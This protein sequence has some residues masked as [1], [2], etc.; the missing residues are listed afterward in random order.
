MSLF[1]FQLEKVS[2]DKSLFLNFL[3]ISYIQLHQ[4]CL[5]GYGRIILSLKALQ[6][7]LISFSKE[8]N[9]PP[10]TSTVLA[11]LKYLR[12]AIII[13]GL[14]TAICRTV[15][16]APV[17]LN[18]M[19]IVAI[20]HISNLRQPSFNTLKYCVILLA[21]TAAIFVHVHADPEADAWPDASFDDLF[22]GRASE[23]ETKN[24][25]QSDD[26]DSETAFDANRAIVAAEKNA[27]AEPHAD[28][29]LDVKPQFGLFV[30][31]TK[32]SVV[33]ETTAKSMTLS[34]RLP[35]AN[36]MQQ[37]HDLASTLSNKI[38]A[39]M[40][41]AVMTSS[42]LYKYRKEAITTNIA[43]CLVKLKN[44]QSHIS[45]LNAYITQPNSV[46]RTEVPSTFSRFCASEFTFQM[47][48]KLANI[49]DLFRALDTQPGEVNVPTAAPPAKEGPAAAPTPAPPAT[50][51]A[52]RIV[53]EQSK[54]LAEDLVL[55]LG[56][57]EGLELRL[58]RF[59]KILEDLSNGEVNA[60]ARVLLQRNDCVPE[61]STEVTTA[62]ECL[63]ISDAFV[64]NI[65]IAKAGKTEVGFQM[66]PV[67]YPTFHSALK[68]SFVQRE[69]DPSQFANV[70][71]CQQDENVFICPHV[72]W[73]ENEC[74]T[75][76]RSTNLEMLFKHCQ[77]AKNAPKGYRAEP[78]KDG[79]L[80]DNLNYNT[81]VTVERKHKLNLSALI[82]PYSYSFIIN[83]RSD[84]QTVPARIPFEVQPILTSWFRDEHIHSINRKLNPPP[85]DHWY[86]FVD[87]DPYKLY[88]L[89][90]Q[91]VATPV[92][93]KTLW[94]YAKAEFYKRFRRIQKK[95]KLKRAA[96]ETDDK[97]INLMREASKKK[98][99]N[100]QES[101]NDE[102]RIELARR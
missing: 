60:Y 101:A 22:R 52:A 86:D 83:P 56:R 6:V 72:H 18:F 3:F 76:D 25:Q 35:D 58:V 67:H 71:D 30:V 57:L 36:E 94:H 75:Y 8:G 62:K 33:S 92:L 95:Q 81:W 41:H 51:P 77:L 97:N 84:S 5:S 38:G 66:V 79:T 28:F 34:V 10:R 1:Y 44:V 16:I 50:T 27:E 96:K 20:I 48:R 61:G 21:S 19:L 42:H 40:R 93:L 39:Q 54:A 43:N 87:N 24:Q 46:H 90:M 80:V 82:V 89:I 59:L 11:A 4:S 7:G 2:I 14:V 47:Y 49:R 99:R 68:G 74:L 91:L 98:R 69:T 100:N 73:R 15:P 64:C 23:P 63:I 32:V 13:V 12:Y 45:S 17:A 53:R 55:I 102:E 78:V 88:N 31:G 29:H 26:S 85:D 70:E 37:T 65:Q 9:M